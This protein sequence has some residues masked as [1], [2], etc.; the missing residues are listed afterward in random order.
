LQLESRP[1][2][3]LKK[4]GTWTPQN[5]K[6]YDFAAEGCTFSQSALTTP[7]SLKSDPKASKMKPKLTQKGQKD[8]PR[9]LRNPQQN[10][11]GKRHIKTPKKMQKHL[12]KKPVLAWE[13][14]ARS[15][16][17]SYTACWRVSDRA[18]T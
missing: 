14:E 2:K 12:Q 8:P 9:T 13:R 15:N 10:R 17:R 5:L 4:Y 6:K 3:S 11:E 18:L 16:L 7:K 1:E